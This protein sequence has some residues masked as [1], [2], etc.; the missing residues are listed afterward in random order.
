MQL[1][2]CPRD[3]LQ[4]LKKIIPTE[5]KVEYIQSLLD[6]GFHTIDFGSFVSA[7]AI[8]QMA[9]T[10]DVI[11]QLDLS[12]SKSKLL[13]IIANERGADEALQYEKIAVLGF[14]FSISPTFQQRN[15]HADQET[16]F[17]RIQNIQDKC[18][19][20][21][22]QLLV[23][24]SMAFGNPYEEDHSLDM[25]AQWADRF[26]AIGI[27]IIALSDT[28][29]LAH[30]EQI[31]EV[32]NYCITTYPKIQFGAHFHATTKNW[33]G[34]LR[35]AYH[36]GCRRFDSTLL[37][38][39]GC[40]MAKDELVGNIATEQ[41]LQFLSTEKIKYAPLNETAFLRSKAL[42]QKIFN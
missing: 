26:D 24:F 9:D 3:A 35:A 20:E 13:A 42:A 34:K 1:V 8:P 36:A 4:G 19:K 29:G 17:I 22:R 32:F 23:Y 15:T 31:T 18:L 38:Y 2:E 5:Q 10:K 11:Q 6:V 12:Q 41:L 21:N 25:I 14:P 27:S 16:A 37:G 33:E 28:V 30:A 7:K 39:G 40:P